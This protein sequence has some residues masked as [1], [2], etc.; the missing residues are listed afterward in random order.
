MPIVN[1]PIYRQLFDFLC[2]ASIAISVAEASGRTYRCRKECVHSDQQDIKQSVAGEPAAH[3][4]K[5][6]VP[7]ATCHQDFSRVRLQ[8]ASAQLIKAVYGARSKHASHGALMMIV[9]GAQ[10]MIAKHRLPYIIKK[11][12]N[13][14]GE[15]TLG[16]HPSAKR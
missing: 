3:E 14:A 4:F 9:K 16:L 2:S 7:V 5:P 10:G 11:E 15:I 8:V 13:G 6:M 12:R 1:I